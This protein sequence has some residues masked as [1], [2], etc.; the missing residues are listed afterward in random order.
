VLGSPL[1]HYASRLPKLKTTT[2]FV[3]HTADE[4]RLKD[5]LAAQVHRPLYIMENMCLVVSKRLPAGFFAA[6]KLRL[7][8]RRPAICSLILHVFHL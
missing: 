3:A 2:D 6:R 5:K 8:T 4:K 7:G 1:G